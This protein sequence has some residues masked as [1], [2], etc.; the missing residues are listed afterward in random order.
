M[1]DRLGACLQ[2]ELH[3]VGEFIAARI[4]SFFKQK[5]SFDQ[6][7]LPELCPE[8]EATPLHRFFRQH[9]LSPEAQLLVLLALAPHLQ[10]DFYDR[11][12][13]RALPEPGDFPQLGG[14]RG[15]NFRGILP[16]GETALFLVAGEDLQRRLHVQ[17]LFSE[18]HLFA[19]GR[20]L[21]LEEMPE[22]E[23]RTSGRMILGQDFVDL[24]TTGQ[25]SR[26]HFS[27]N[28]PA[29]LMRTE[30][31]WTDLVLHA[32]TLEQIRELEVWVK[33]GEVLMNRWGMRRKLKP[34]Y[35]ALFYGPAG[36]GKTLT[37]SLL[38]KYTGKDV[39]R[40]DL[41]MLISKFIG[42]TEKNLSNLFAKAEN[43]NW[44]LFFDE[45]DALF[46]K[47]TNVRDAHD[48]FANQEVSYLLQRVE[49]Y[50]GLVIL[51]S[52]FKSN[53]DEAFSRRFQSIIN[54]P[55]PG[56]DERHRLWQNAFPANVHLAPDVSLATLGEK[57]ELTGAQ[58]VNVAQYACLRA[59][60]AK[61]EQ[62]HYRDLYAGIKREFLKDGRIWR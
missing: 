40:I 45:A 18:D 46:G 21:W 29:Q 44:I 4:H 28:F 19:R 6:V 3:R 60:D 37:A 9:D 54:F 41:S 20:V 48:K 1:R 31:E 42:E 11:I 25:V 57:Y 10:P 15:R 17:Q 24:F 59:L 56:S 62:I 32:D 34:G 55:M 8:G 38:G 23:P 35:R 16:T 13:A 58:I 2:A 61:R 47:R 51:A 12:V 53:I 14:A 39:Y 33:H 30:L 22:G 49:E 36:T 52:N 5:G 43:K 7:A 27:L 26:P 50:N